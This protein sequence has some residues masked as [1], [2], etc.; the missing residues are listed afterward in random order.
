MVA[1]S[2]NEHSLEGDFQMVPNDLL[3]CNGA[4]E[5]NNGEQLEEGM[6]TDERWTCKRWV[7]DYGW[8]KRKYVCTLRRP[9]M[10]EVLST[11]IWGVPPACLGSR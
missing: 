4:D 6:E 11:R 3:N 2:A 5:E 1:C 10:G 7:M 9:V 8:P